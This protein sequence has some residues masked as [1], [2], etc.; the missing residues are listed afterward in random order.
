MLQKTGI[1]FLRRITSHN[2]MCQLELVK[3]IGGAE[4][5]GKG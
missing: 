3:N 5:E 2:F 1:I 4:G